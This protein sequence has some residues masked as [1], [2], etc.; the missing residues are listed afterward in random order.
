MNRRAFCLQPRDCS[1]PSAYR[2]RL[3]PLCP[4][5]RHVHEQQAASRLARLYQPY[6]VSN[7]PKLSRLHVQASLS[8]RSPAGPTPEP[9]HP[10]PSQHTHLRHVRRYERLQRQDF[11]RGQLRF[12]LTSAV[13][14]TTECFREPS[15]RSSLLAEPAC[16]Q[17]RFK[18]RVFVRG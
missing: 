3:A 2:G 17:L 1:R 4:R 5:V 13:V 7:I 11:G 6:S 12:T 8:Y 14:R 9:A 16:N 18:R 15:S 10:A